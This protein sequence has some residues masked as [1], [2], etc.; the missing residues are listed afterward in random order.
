ML[1]SSEK[2]DLKNALLFLCLG[3]FFLNLVFITPHGGFIGGQSFVS[4]VRSTEWHVYG[5]WLGVWCSFQIMLLSIAALF[6]TL[7]FEETMWFLR[8]NAMANVAI[9]SLT[10]PLLG[11]G[12]GL[13]YLAKAVF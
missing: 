5:E 13:Y 4:V 8:R 9:V 12:V 3:L 6:L 1:Y 11:F 10:L 7:C 2:K